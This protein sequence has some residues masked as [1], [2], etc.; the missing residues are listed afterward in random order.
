MTEN[1]TDILTHVAYFA[2]LESET[3]K[4]VARSARQRHYDTDQVV[5]TEGEAA[6]GLYL[7]ES[8][9]LKAVK[10]APDGR[11][12]VLRFIG[13]GETF[14]ATGVFI[15]KPTSATVIA[16][17]PAVVWVIQRNILHRLV[18][19]YPSLARAVI[20]NLAERLRH[21]VALVEDLSL[22][23]VKAR[24]IRYLLDE[25]DAETLNRSAWATQTELAARLGTVPDVLGRALR[26]LVDEQLIEVTRRQITI[27]DRPR[28]TAMADES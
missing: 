2:A 28:L 4:V 11:E 22:R 23:T 27:L 15:D 13:P 16:L 6:A 14:N 5:F 17:E 21:L 20:Q 1:P 8:G 9:W 3:L 12:Q 25:S 10:L 24:L 26:S 19:T 7:V 18:D